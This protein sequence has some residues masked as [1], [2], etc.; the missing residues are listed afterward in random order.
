[1]R[2]CRSC[3][4]PLKHPL[5]GRR[6][7]YCSR[8]CKKRAERKRALRAESFDPVSATK[9]PSEGEPGRR[10]RGF[11]TVSPP[12]QPLEDEEPHFYRTWTGE[13]YLAHRRGAFVTGPRDYSAEAARAVA[14]SEGSGASEG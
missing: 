6:R 8:A 3:G 5:T 7:R 11:F 14:R 13:A 4:G 1:M 12:P 2:T 9:Q 10:R